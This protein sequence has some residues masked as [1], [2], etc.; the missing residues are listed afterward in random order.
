MN[1]RDQAARRLKA[2]TDTMTRLCTETKLETVLELLTGLTRD[3]VACDRVSFWFWDKPGKK[4]WTLAASSETGRLTVPDFYGLV[5]ETVRSAEVQRIDDV[6][7][8]PRFNPA[9]DR[10][11]GYRTRSLLT[12]RLVNSHQEVIGAYQCINRLTEDGQPALFTEEDVTLLSVVSAF[13]GKCLEGYGLRAERA[14]LDAELDVAGEI[15]RDILSEL[16]PLDRGRPFTLDAAVRPSRTM[17]GDFF[18]AYRLEDGRIA[19]TVADVSGKGIAAALFMMNAKAV[20]KE[21]ALNRGGSPG[22]VLAYAN[23]RLSEENSTGMFVT[24]WLGYL[25]PADG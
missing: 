9:V 3:L 17:G 10:Q 22:D 21:R 23:S 18:D 12:V 15:Q 8:D 4:L 6:Y 11:T 25:D 19:L 14:A 16:A 1:A 24:A 20:L 2:I 7:A 5:A 13:A